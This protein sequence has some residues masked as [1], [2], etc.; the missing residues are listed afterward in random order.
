MD[1]ADASPVVVG[2][3][4]VDAL[5]GRATRPHRDLD[6][7]VRA[8]RIDVVVEQLE[9][10]AMC[11]GIDWL[12][13]RVEFA[14]DRRTVDLHP[15]YDDGAGG[16]WQHG[17]GDHRFEYPA[18]TLTSGTIAGR[19]VRCLSAAKQI[20]LHSGYEPRPEDLHDLELLR[21]I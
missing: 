12:P 1:V 13:V 15:A 16:W 20:E 2:G 8:D 18:S 19:I 10:L 4:G 7:L 11:R 9:A 6:V 5:V 21:S 14:D 17:L 3:W